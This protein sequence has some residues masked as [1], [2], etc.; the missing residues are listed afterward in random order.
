MPKVRSRAPADVDQTK[1]RKRI[2]IA[3]KRATATPNKKQ[4]TQIMLSTSSESELDDKQIEFV[5]E[6]VITT[7]GL[8]HLA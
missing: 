3:N 4:K 7:I 2:W 8:L 6:K 5:Q 1:L